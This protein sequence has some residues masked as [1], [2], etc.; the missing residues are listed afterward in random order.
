MGKYVSV[1]TNCDIQGDVLIKI[2][3]KTVPGLIPPEIVHNVKRKLG[4]IF[5]ENHNSVSLDLQRGQS[6]GVMTSCVVTQE[7]LGQQSERH[8]E[9]T[10]CVTGQSNCV[11]THI[12]G[13]RVGNTEKVEKAGQKAECVQ[14]IENRQSYETETEKQKFI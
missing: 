3:D 5:K 12:G 11:E 1:Q 8:K 14:N 4:C 10:Q 7:E 13:A 6:I 9:D 2:R